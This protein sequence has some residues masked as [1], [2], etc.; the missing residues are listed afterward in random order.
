MQNRD[1]GEL[2]PLSKELRDLFK[3]EGPAEV[4]KVI[5]YPLDSPVFHE[6]EVLEI[7]GGFWRITHIWH[8][9]MKLKSI[10]AAEAAKET[11]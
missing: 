7:K 11:K 8:G 2:S 3:R 6:G 10:S 1:T 4:A 9:R 5:G